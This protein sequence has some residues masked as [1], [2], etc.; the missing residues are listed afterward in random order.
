M[1]PM[2]LFEKR[3]EHPLADPDEAKRV[4][5]ALAESRP[6]EALQ[7]LQ[8]W[9]GTLH[10]FDGFACDDRLDLVKRLDAVSRPLLAKAF[11]EFFAHVHLRDRAQH[12]REQMLQA[13]W[14]KLAGAYARCVSDNERGEKRAKEIR[15]ELPLA[16]ARSYRASFLAAKA[17]CMMYLSIA[18]KD[19]HALYQPFA[20]AEVAHFDSAPARVYE[21]EAQS[22][23]RAELAKLLAF[24]LAAR[25]LDRFA[26]SFVWSREPSAECTAV[27]DLGAGGPPRFAAPGHARSAGQRY[28]GAGPALAKLKELESLSARDL[29]SDELRFGTEFTPPQIVTVIRH[30]L[31]YLG[32]TPPRRRGARVPIAGSIE[33]VRGFAAICQRVTAIDVATNAELKEDLK[34]ATEKA[35]KGLQVEAE[36][37]EAVPETWKVTDRSDWGVGVEIPAGLGTWVEPGVLCGI[38]DSE[39]APW[40]AGIIRRL[41]ASAAGSVRC[42]LQVLSKK[43]VSVWLRVLGREGQ[44]ASNWE[45]S[46]G[47]F[48]YDHTRAIVLPEAKAGDRPVL[49]LEGTKFVPDQICE[50][51]MGERSRHIKLVEFVE[52]GADYLRAAFIWMAPGA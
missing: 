11:A 20:F 22:T 51:V 43:P 46:T 48:A 25:V 33:V 6:Q 37:I 13:Y 18:P 50:V 26:I 49:L 7:E 41:D 19:W 29:L 34:V 52:A 12:G 17:R 42:G 5:E 15:D 9:F 45:T 27:I 28:F 2:R 36:E 16:L 14:S 3:P 47:S 24:Q 35:K 8:H 31:R 32:P 1:P 21:R 30:L 10:E 38:R 4:L 44:Q 23:P 40:G 39:K